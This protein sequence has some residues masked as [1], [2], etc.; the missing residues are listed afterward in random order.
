MTQ[1]SYNQFYDIEYRKLYVGKEVATKE[2][3]RNQYYR[4]KRI[5]QYLENNLKINL[6]NQKVLEV[7]IGAGGILQYFKEKGN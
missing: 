5:Y 2:F 7:G 3:F 1:K 4:G 6:T